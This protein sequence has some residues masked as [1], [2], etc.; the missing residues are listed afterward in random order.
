V[1]RVAGADDQS[2]TARQAANAFFARQEHFATTTST[3]DVVAG[4]L[5]EG[6]PEVVLATAD[7]QTAGR[8]RDG[9]TWQAKP[10]DA[11]LLRMGF[12]PTW[13]DPDRVW[14]LAAIIALAMADAA[15]EVAGLADGAI[16][17]KWPND[18][19]VEFEQAD[20]D[21]RRLA[22]LAGVLGETS[23]LGTDD[24][25]AIVG[26]GINADWRREDFPADLAATMTSLR[27]ASGGRPIDRV[28]LLDGFLGRIE[29]RVDGLR[30]GHFALSDWQERQVTT[31]RDVDLLLPD[32]G[33]RRVRAVG[34]DG[35]SG[36]LVIED[37][38]E[39]GADR[40]VHSGEVV[41]VRLSE[42]QGL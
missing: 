40:I 3:N 16:R 26:I 39:G 2:T 13:L 32:G 15:E 1:I 6:T 34:V 28:Q 12:R 20:S 27:D 36:G 35:N 41:H 30:K 4:W 18:L 9:R 8:G 31:G 17:L 33:R 42:P 37:E 11:L 10:G 14:R 7:E 29:M 23:G 21:R 25:R 5:A 38:D 19:I 24:P 22:K